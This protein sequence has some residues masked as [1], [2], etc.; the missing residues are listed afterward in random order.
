MNMNPA[1]VLALIGELYGQIAAL[2]EENAALRATLAGRPG[3][4]DQSE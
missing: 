4:R 2:T 1:A 3:D